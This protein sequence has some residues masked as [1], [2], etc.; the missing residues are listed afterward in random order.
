MLNLLAKHFHRIGSVRFKL[1]FHESCAQPSLI[2]WGVVL[3]LF[4]FC[5]L[6]YLL[7]NSQLPAKG[8]VQVC[9]GDPTSLHPMSRVLLFYTLSTY[10]HLS[11]RMCTN[12]DVIRV[13]NVYQMF[14]VLVQFCL[15]LLV[16]YCC[17]KQADC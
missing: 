3:C 6:V 11:I 15:S 2:A 1:A 5:G 7:C 16:V 13:V 14:M 17:Y 8:S 10:L 9:H 4:C 12:F